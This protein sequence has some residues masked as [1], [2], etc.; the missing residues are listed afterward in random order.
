MQCVQM[1]ILHYLMTILPYKNSQFIYYTTNLAYTVT[2]D[3]SPSY[4]LHTIYHI[5]HVADDHY[6]RILMRGTITLT[7]FPS[8]SLVISQRDPCL[9][10]LPSRA[11]PLL[12]QYYGVS[13]GCRGS[14]Q[15]NSVI[16]CVCLHGECRQ[17]FPRL[18]LMNFRAAASTG[19]AFHQGS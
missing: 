16:W 8:L 9:S 6:Q 18:R 13:T 3:I 10:A 15:W 4:A 1:V 11:W 2:Y 17:D 7:P 19:W 14:R 12:G 5:V